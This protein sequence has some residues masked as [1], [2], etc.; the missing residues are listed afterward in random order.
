MRAVRQAIL[1][2]ARSLGLEPRLRRAQRALSRGA[3]RRGYVDDE[4]TGLLLRLALPADS[5]CVDVGA[6][7]GSVLEDIVA[8]FPDAQHVA[9]EP[10]PE[11]A[12]ALR[13]RFPQ[14]DVRAAALS[15][16]AGT[17]TLHR[18]VEKPGHSS[19]GA[20]EA[21][22]G[23]VED[24]EVP[25]Q[26][27]D[28]ALPEGF[29]PAFIKVDVEGAEEQVFRGMLGTL[30]AHRPLV[31]FEHGDHAARFGTRPETIHDLLCGEAGLRLFDIDGAGPF[32]R[33]EFAAHAAAGGIWTW[34]ARS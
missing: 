10:L 19:L 18:V 8:C 11:L 16:H 1:R 6:N 12:E 25:V 15:D 21:A 28:D 23:T 31:V 32:T 29:V 33:E 9:F 3:K 7:V 27:L 26:R 30:R 14:V 5:S 17:A 13:H 2:A 22:L 4:H 20:V 24:V 34:V